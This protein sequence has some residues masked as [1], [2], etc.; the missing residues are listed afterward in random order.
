M[1]NDLTC[2]T[3]A[4]TGTV[5]RERT[6]EVY[7]DRRDMHLGTVLEWADVECD[8]CCGTGQLED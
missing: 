5:N 6:R 3:C 2:P 8:E 1:T 7:C 4:G